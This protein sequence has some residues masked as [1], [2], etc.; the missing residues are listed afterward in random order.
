MILP[1]SLILCSELSAAYAVVV[2]ME[3]D[4][5]IVNKNNNDKHNVIT[6]SN[7]FLPL[8]FIRANSLSKLSN[9]YTT[10][11]SFFMQ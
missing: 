1:R 3:C 5:W 9:F 11:K 6:V 7:M 2:V 10:P 8:T 4:G